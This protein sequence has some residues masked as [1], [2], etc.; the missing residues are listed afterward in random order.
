MVSDQRFLI[1]VEPRTERQL[2]IISC[3]RR[4]GSGY[5]AGVLIN[6]MRKH[7]EKLE[8]ASSTH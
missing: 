5:T 2:V 6:R 4:V 3:E 1:A 7:V 8:K